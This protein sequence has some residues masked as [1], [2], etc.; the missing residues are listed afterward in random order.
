MLKGNQSKC[1]NC[2]KVFEYDSDGFYDREWPYHETAQVV[3]YCDEVCCNMKREIDKD[4]NQ[5][6]A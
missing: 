6:A 1:P 3:Q 4:T 2:R 5:V